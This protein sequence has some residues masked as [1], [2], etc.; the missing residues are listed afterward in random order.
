MASKSSFQDCIDVVSKASRDAISPSQAKELVQRMMDQVQRTKG[1]ENANVE[2]VIRKIGKDLTESDKL[3]SAIQSRNAYLT[4][5]AQTRIKNYVKNFAT[6][7]E[8]LRAFMNG[9]SKIAKEGR[10]SVFYQGK[11]LESKYIGRL[12]DGLEKGGLMDHFKSGDLDKQVFQELWE[13][14]RDDGSGRPGISGS[15]K[16][17]HM[18]RIVNTIHLDMIDRENRAGAYVRPREGYI[19]RQMHDSDAIRRAGGMG[20]NEHSNAA[21]FRAWSQFVLPLLD[22]EKTFGDGLMG[23]ETDPMKFL[24]SFHEGIL[25]GVHDSPASSTLDINSAIRTPGALAKQVS[26]ARVLHF[27]DADS[28]YK[29][30]EAF[31]AKSFRDSVLGQIH[32]RARSTSIMENFGPNP[33][34]TFDRIRQDL[35]VAAKSSPNDDAAVKSIDNWKT[36]ASF[37]ELMGKNDRPN[38]PNMSRMMAG[39]R[40]ITNLSKLGGVTIT[41]LTHKAF[42]HTEMTYQGIHGMDAMSKNL[43]LLAEGRPTGERKSMLNLMGAA[44]DGF[45][46][47][48]AS[49]FTIHDNQTGMLYKLQQKFFQINGMN[50]WNDVHKGAAAELMSA[51]LAE[52]AHLDS[53]HLPP[54]LKKTLSLYGIEGDKW[55]AIRRATAENNGRNYLTP[56]SLWQNSNAQIK[57]LNDARNIPDSK[58]NQA[59][60]RDDL[61]TRLRTYLADRV[62]IAVPTPGNAEKVLTHLNTQAGTPLGEGVRTAMLFKSFV[63]SVVNKV[64]AREMYGHG[65][66]TAMQWIRNDKMG[67][68]RMAQTIALATVGGYISGAL[69]D[70]LHGRTPKDPM[71]PKTIQDA[72][73]RGGGLGI[74]GDFLFSEYD[75]SYRSAMATAA[76]PVFGQLDNL[77]AMYSKLKSGDN[78][79]GDAGKFALSNAPLINLFYIRPVLDYLILWHLQEMM[80]PGSL[81]RQEN[82]EEKNNGQGFFIRP[83]DHA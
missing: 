14:N 18:A 4:H 51:H 69:K 68:F 48:V 45:I 5:I 25:T 83:S 47:N 21:S 8:G 70:A 1:G 61:D 3:L 26:E 52:H 9:S 12:I 59:R 23:G 33:E 60:M 40:A 38:N 64:L 58:E 77:A 17:E 35:K 74:Y 7:G 22:H 11:A 78:I 76:G 27:K 73:A 56:D 36:E 39:V 57:E 54:E 72:L 15:P 31:G 80:D 79:A 53:E 10:H 20:Y 32:N 24:K 50:W 65:S 19:M 6:P 55:D 67:N 16:A 37:R 75:R 46:G 13:L 2:S 43:T 81:R 82:S 41:A 71:D 66:N 44:V 30:N 28:T 62:D 42:F 34:R 29:Y 49:R 63:I